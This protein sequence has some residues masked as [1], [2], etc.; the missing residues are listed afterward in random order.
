MPKFII[1]ELE[2]YPPISLPEHTRSR[3]TNICDFLRQWGAPILA[4]WCTIAKQEK[5]F[6]YE[7]DVKW[8][9]L[10]TEKTGKGKDLRPH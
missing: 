7:V 6:R 2:M 1:C 8:Q 9:T 3:S 10:V 5:A 4:S